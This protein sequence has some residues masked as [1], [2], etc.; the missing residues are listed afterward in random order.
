MSPSPDP[1]NYLPNG[2]ASLRAA[3]QNDLDALRVSRL[4]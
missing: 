3:S 2:A 1:R 4:H